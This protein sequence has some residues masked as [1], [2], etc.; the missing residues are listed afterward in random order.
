MPSKKTAAKKSKAPKKAAAK[1]AAAKKSAAK[2]AA[3]SKTVTT[4]KAAEAKAPAKKAATPAAR[5]KASDFVK[6]PSH[7][8]AVFK[9]YSKRAPQ[10]LF[11]LEDVREILKKRE[12]DEQRQARDQEN[13][14]KPALEE[15][16]K[17]AVQDA[18]L[19][20]TPPKKSRHQQA[21][22]EDILGLS[23]GPAGSP[24]PG[25][26]K[27]EKKYEKYYNLLLE[28]RKE[29][30]EELHL[31]SNDTLKR[32]QKDDAGD[33]SISVDA[34]TDNFDRD[35]ALSLLSTEQDA[36]KEIEAA[37]NRIHKGTYG[38]CEVTGE[39]INPERLEAV[40]FTRFSVEGQKQ[41]ESSARKRVS[42]AGAF[43]NESS[44]EKISFGD[45]D[46]DN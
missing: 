23:A 42:R 20:E 25:Q 22:L 2:K 44:G 31:H 34:G 37:I 12:K 8:P 33:I 39:P 29:V 18:P 21:S 1:K 13:G 10:I 43:L 27:V 46:G 28:L 5:P 30:R 26:P 3:T 19:E 36:L 11:T 38:L 9:P 17:A 4:K 32:S 14:Q 15:A 35:F 16:P 40:P 24:N 45:D 41:Y 6:R 7:T